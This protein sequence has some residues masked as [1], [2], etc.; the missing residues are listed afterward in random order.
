MKKLIAIVAILSTVLLIFRVFC[1]GPEVFAIPQGVPGSVELTCKGI[2]IPITTSKYLM[3]DELDNW[4]HR[5]SLKQRYENYFSS[6][7]NRSTF[8]I[9]IDLKAQS[10]E[11]FDFTIEPVSEPIYWPPRDPISKYTEVTLAPS[12]YILKLEIA[13]EISSVTEVDRR[14]GRYTI[15]ATSLKSLPDKSSKGYVE[16]GICTLVR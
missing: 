7:E 12:T 13:G 1:G 3:V 4:L 5:P 15:L 6:D 10:A 14:S 9:R 8:D 2:R 16:R 11:V